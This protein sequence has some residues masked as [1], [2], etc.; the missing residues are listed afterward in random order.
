MNGRTKRDGVRPAAAWVCCLWFSGG[1][2]VTPSTRVGG[3]AVPN[4]VAL[5]YDS[6][7]FSQRFFCR[8]HLGQLVAQNGGPAVVQ[9]V[10]DADV[11]DDFHRLRA[12]RS[13]GLSCS[14]THARDVRGHVY[15][16]AKVANR[17][18]GVGHGGRQ[19][20]LL[21]RWT[22][23]K[24]QRRTRSARTGGYNQC[25]GSNGPVSHL[26]NVTIRNSFIV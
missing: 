22:N 17:N 4:P 12:A 14:H 20:M 8:A 3:G 25:R 15:S 24:P 10:V 11:L 13:E 16:D 6:L 18:L 23:P 5:R 1:V 7:T 21:E 9:R 19:R 26:P 2:R